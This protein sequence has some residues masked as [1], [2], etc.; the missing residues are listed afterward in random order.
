MLERDQIMVARG[1][2]GEQAA[3][4]D[5]KPDFTL[6]GGYYSMG[7]LPAMY[8]F[9]FDVTVP[10]QRTRRAAAVVEQRQLAEASRRTFQAT[11]LMLQGRLEEEYQ[12]ASSTHRLAV[13]Y[14]D[15]VL[16]QARLALE[17]SLASYQTGGVDFLSVL[18]NFTAVLEYEMAYYDELASFHAA[19]SRLEEMAGQPVTH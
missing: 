10:V 2:L 16:P 1:A 5:Y 15:T 14:R 9:R 13:L 17:S 4:L 12:M 3:R 8:E 7:R 11:R 18:T 19:V 6:S